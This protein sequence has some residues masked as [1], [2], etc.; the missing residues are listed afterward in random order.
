MDIIKDK[1]MPATKMSSAPGIK[2]DF[3]P[4]FV[5]TLPRVSCDLPLQNCFFVYTV[6]NLFSS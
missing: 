6:M 3:M 5:K 1:A 2:A 4:N